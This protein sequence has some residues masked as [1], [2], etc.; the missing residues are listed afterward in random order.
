MSLLMVLMPWS[1]RPRAGL[2]QNA[3]LRFWDSEV[4]VVG[5]GSKQKGPQ[6]GRGPHGEE[7]GGLADPKRELPVGLCAKGW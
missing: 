4:S 7:S 6:L 3:F 1:A 5:Q 2:A